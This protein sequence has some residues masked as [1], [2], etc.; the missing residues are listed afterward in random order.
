MNFHLYPFTISDFVVKSKTPIHFL[1]I[2][3]SLGTI[4]SKNVPIIVGL[5]NKKGSE[6]LYQV[7]LTYPCLCNR[8]VGHQGIQTLSVHISGSNLR[9]TYPLRKQKRLRTVF[10]PYLSTLTYTINYGLQ[11]HPFMTNISKYFK[12]KQKNSREDIF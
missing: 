12:H 4:L 10:H 7:L 6:R 8:A 1:Y 11:K 9:A 5:T 2:H 3:G